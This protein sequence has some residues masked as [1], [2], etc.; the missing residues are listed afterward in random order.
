M[1]H[2][3]EEKKARVLGVIHE[4]T[5]PRFCELGNGWVGDNIVFGTAWA[6][7]TYLFG[8]FLIGVTGSVS[9]HI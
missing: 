5:Y 3:P 4:Q 6:P 8:Q 1:P 7:T 9:I 2:V